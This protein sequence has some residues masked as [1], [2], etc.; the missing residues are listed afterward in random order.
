M[1]MI[2]S[3]LPKNFPIRQYFPVTNRFFVQI[4]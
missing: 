1:E 3:Q 4:T 2:G